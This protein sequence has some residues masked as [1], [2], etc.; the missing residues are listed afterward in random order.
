MRRFLSTVLLGALLAAAMVQPGLSYGQNP[1]PAFPPPPP[2]TLKIGDSAPDF[3]LR[4]QNG[5][6]VALKDF[7][8]KK[9]VVL[10]FF[11]F[12]FTAG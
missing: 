9:T 2:L 1:K 12:A 5:K 6:E 7:K 3:V 10:A 4:D 8:G 11:I